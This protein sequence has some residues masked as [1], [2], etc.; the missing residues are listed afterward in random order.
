M[1]TKKSCIIP[2]TLYKII[3]EIC[4]VRIFRVR[5]SMGSNW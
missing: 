1:I 3:S 4:F 2:V 5:I